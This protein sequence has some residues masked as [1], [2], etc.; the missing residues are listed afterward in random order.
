MIGRDPPLVPPP[1]PI[2]ELRRPAE[3]LYGPPT[4]ARRVTRVRYIGPALE[5]SELQRL[6][7]GGCRSNLNSAR[8]T[9]G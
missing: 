2:P 8:R 3:P 4:S 7:D 6:V 9:K 1:T 5:R